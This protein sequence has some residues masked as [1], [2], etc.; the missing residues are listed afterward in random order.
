MKELSFL[1][2]DIGNSTV[3]CAFFGGGALFGSG[4][5]PLRIESISTEIALAACD[6][7]AVLREFFER[8]GIE[9]KTACAMVSS[10]V[11][12]LTEPCLYV[13]EEFCEKKPLLIESGLYNHLRIKIPESR[14]RQIGTD[15]V[16]NTEEAYSRFNSPCIV[17]DFGTALTFT[18]IDS[19]GVLLGTAIAPGLA[20]AAQS[21]ANKAAQLFLVPIE[22]PPTPL[23][24]NTVEAMQSGLVYGWASLAQSLV[25]RFKTEMRRQGVPRKDIKVIGTGGFCGLIAPIAG[26][27]DEIDPCLIFYGLRRIYAQRIANNI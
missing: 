6:H 7:A 12:R 4:A 9:K 3:A 14:A 19:G 15:I 2:I 22:A 8:F 13:L 26:I 21:L 16:C 24:R 20:C 1:A 23:G 11:P 18:A 27:F 17:V 5:E 25:E 10:V